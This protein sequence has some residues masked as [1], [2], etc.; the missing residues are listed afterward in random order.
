MQGTVTMKLYDELIRKI[1]ALLPYEQAKHF[2]YNEAKLWPENE[3]HEMILQKETAFELGGAGKPAVSITCVTSDEKLVPENQILIWGQDL[4]KMEADAPYAR[5][6]LL[7]SE[8][9]E[10][11]T[12][13]QVYN[14]LQDIDF[15]KYHVYPK[16]YMIRTSGQSGREQVRISKKAME[17]G[18]TFS[19]IGATFL[20]KYLLTG[21]VKRAQI[22]FVTL[23]DA[24]YA[25]LEKTGFLARDIKNSLSIIKNGLPTECSI[26]DIRSIC[27]EVEGLRELHFGKQ[28][29][30]NRGLGL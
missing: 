29:R 1:Q 2:E 27:D 8:P 11:A 9:M 5:I 30:Q 17:Q 25:E 23:P 13:E 3:N 22:L 12:S 14:D 21:K 24:N 15:V 18:V 28:K 7:L 10:E 16:G 19:R 4:D 6:S 26:C 20:H